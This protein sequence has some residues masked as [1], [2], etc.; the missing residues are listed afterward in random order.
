MPSSQVFKKF[1]SGKLRSGGPRGP[2]VKDREQAIAIY[3]SERRKEKA[4]SGVYPEKR[5]R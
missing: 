5:R 4:N 3:L 1:Q 2:V